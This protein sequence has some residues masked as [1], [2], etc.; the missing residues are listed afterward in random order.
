MGSVLPETCWASYKSEVKFWHTVAS[1]WIFFFVDYTMVHEHQEWCSKNR[2]SQKPQNLT[3]ILLFLLEPSTWPY[4]KPAGSSS[5]TDI[6]FL[7]YIFNII[8]SST[9][10][11]YEWCFFRVKWDIV[12]SSI[13]CYKFSGGVWKVCSWYCNSLF[14]FFVVISKQQYAALRTPWIALTVVP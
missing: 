4:V 12:S 7:L 5:Q 10:S 13:L 3:Y 2:P 6:P 8:T 1:C 9:P 11:Y 14:Q